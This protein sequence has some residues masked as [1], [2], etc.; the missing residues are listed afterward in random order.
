MIVNFALGDFE[1]TPQ[2]RPVMED[3]PSTQT[4]PGSKEKMEVLRERIKKQLPLHHDSDN[5]A[6]DPLGMGW[7]LDDGNKEPEPIESMS[8]N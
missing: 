8:S 5:K 4:R 3:F 6:I 2:L 1:F 7:L